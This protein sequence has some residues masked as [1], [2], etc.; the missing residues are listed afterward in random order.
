MELLPKDCRFHYQRAC[1][2]LLSPVP[3]RK[4]AE[5]MGHAVVR[6]NAGHA[7]VWA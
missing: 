7:G 6:L 2:F 5:G 4:K 3:V 1:P